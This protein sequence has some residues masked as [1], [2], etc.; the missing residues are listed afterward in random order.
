MAP[1]AQ[2][3]LLAPI[4]L[5]LPHMSQDNTQLGDIRGRLSQAKWGV[6]SGGGGN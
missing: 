4:R 1:A 3:G 2:C 6:G 5:P